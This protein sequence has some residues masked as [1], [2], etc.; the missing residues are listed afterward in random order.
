MLRAPLHEQEIRKVIGLPGTGERTVDGVAR[1]DDASD[2][3][4]YFINKR[5][6]PEVIESLNQRRGCIVITP[7]NPSLHSIMKDS[8]VLEVADP[9]AAIAKVMTFIRAEHRSPPWVKARQIAETANISPLAV[10]GD[11]V[12]I[13]DGVTI[14]PFCVIDQD[15]SIRRASIVKSGARINPRVVIGEESVIRSNVVIDADGYGF[16]RDEAGNKTRIAHLGGVMIGNHVEIGESSVIEAGTISPTI[17]EDYA[18]LAASVFVGHNVC[19]QRNASVTPGVIIA[20]S[21]II[22]ADTW[23][24]INS[25]IRDGRRVGAHALVGMDSSVQEDLPDNTIARAPVPE[26]KTRS[27]NDDHHTIGFAKPYD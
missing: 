3:C 27:E 25:S 24:G 23:I 17:I 12:E 2:R 15:V 10:I 19:I 21:A 1:L 16:V 11:E 8:V 5:I 20:G 13:G 14:E 9:R 22:G 6:T 4:L 18:K 26:I 7:E